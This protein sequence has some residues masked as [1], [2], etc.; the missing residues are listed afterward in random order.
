MEARPDMAL[1]DKSEGG[2]KGRR[3]GGRE[4]GRNRMEINRWKREG[5]DR[6]REMRR[7][8]TMKRI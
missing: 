2:R 4:G 1:L 8:K 5:E 6:G 7:K 3:N